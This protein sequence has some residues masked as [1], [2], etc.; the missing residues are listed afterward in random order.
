M[1]KKAVSTYAKRHQGASVREHQIHEA[2]KPHLVLGQGASHAGKGIDGRPSL[3]R[4]AR[5][6]PFSAAAAAAGGQ[7]FGRE[8][9]GRTAIGDGNVGGGGGGWGRGQ[10]N[11]SRGTKPD[12][13][14][15]KR[16]EELGQEQQEAPKH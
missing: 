15:E 2:D 10:V 3:L 9:P 1:N 4:Q 14:V 11:A 12:F 6:G 16:L 13:V 7:H 5:R 8:A